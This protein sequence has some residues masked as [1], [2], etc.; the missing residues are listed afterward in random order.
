M[1]SH[2]TPNNARVNG[3]KGTT[4]QKKIQANRLN[5]QR[6]TGP[7]SSEGKR[8]SSRNAA[9]HGL[10]TKDI[11]VT[12]RGCKEDQSEFDA[13]LSEFRDCYRPRDTAE[14]FSVRE[15]AISYWKSARALR[16]ERAE[17]TCAGGEFKEPDEF[18]RM[19]IAIMEFEP[20][21]D[22]Y[23][24]QIKTSRG[25]R[26]LLSKLEQARAEVRVRVRCLRS[27]K[28]GSLPTK[29]G[30]KSP[31]PEAEK[32]FSGLWKRKLQI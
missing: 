29:I 26:F 4:S 22:V 13:L 23:R 28:G 25:I 30:P 31:S 24:T 9:K 2:P 12:S 3:T 20:A 15:L 18:S 27:C 17:I 16:C 32:L 7:R 11:V 8:I 14:D 19:E 1:P 5:A 21:A 6:G 10:L